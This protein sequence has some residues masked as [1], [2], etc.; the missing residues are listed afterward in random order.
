M[1]TLP[2]FFLLACCSAAVTASAAG[3]P[4]AMFTVRVTDELG[5]AMTNAE[6]HA[7][8]VESIKPGWGWG[9]GKEMQ[10]RGKT[11]TNGLC[12][13]TAR[14]EG[15]AGIAAGKD[16]YYWS[17]GYKVLFTNCLGILAKKWHP[18]NPVVDVVLKR[19]GN[20]V[21]M[22]ARWV[23]NAA[24]PKEGEA[25]GYDLQKGDWVTPHGLGEVVDLLFRSDRAPSRVVPSQYGDV[26]LFDD[27]L[28]ISFPNEGDGIQSML[29]PDRGG[30]S[31]L[32]LPA[33]A[34]E[35]G[36]V[37]NLVKRVAQEQDKP[38]FSTIE[39]DANYFFRVRTKKN[40]AGEIVSALYGK[41]H[42]DFRFGRVGELQFR[43]YLNPTP[44]DRNMEF[45]PSRNLFQNL[46]SLEEVR[47]P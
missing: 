33:I 47:E 12:V 35:N 28:T 14:C 44:N 1:K 29:V 3:L 16:G 34:P 36:Y 46:T 41:I 22:Y 11:D 38:I 5:F 13:I 7:G 10:W 43:Y 17:S 9:G 4:E 25:V 26:R 23:Q 2:I 6:V 31:N 37:T 24:I 20:P 39:K 21:P 19:I 15:E 32:R 30:R 40:E 27:T 18:W 42:G 45:D 8:F